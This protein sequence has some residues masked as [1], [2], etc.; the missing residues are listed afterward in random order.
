MEEYNNL[1]SLSSKP[2]MIFMVIIFAIFVIL[3]ET[4]PISNYTKI[5]HFNNG[6][7]LDCN[8]WDGIL[9]SNENSVLK[10]EEIFKD[11]F[12]YSLDRCKIK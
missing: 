4:D 5:E 11:K 1:R 9:L 10:D 6:G 2:K 7:K 8:G 3:I 12:F